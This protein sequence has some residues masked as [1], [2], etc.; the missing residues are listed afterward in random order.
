[1]TQKSH[2]LKDEH[3]SKILAV[4]VLY[5]H[6]SLKTPGNKWQQR[7]DKATNCCVPISLTDLFSLFALEASGIMKNIGEAIQFLHAVNIAH[8]DV[9]VCTTAREILKITNR[10]VFHSLLT[11]LIFPAAGEFIVLLKE[12]ECP[13]QAHRLWL[14]EGNHYS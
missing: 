9:K 10:C 3:I 1:M 13:T 6:F 4:T 14:R 5:F 8:R 12:A 2:L 7:L 11:F